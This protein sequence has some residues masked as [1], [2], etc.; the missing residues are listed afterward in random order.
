MC[1]KK[2]CHSAVP[3]HHNDFQLETMRVD[4]SFHARKLSNY[5][6]GSVEAPIFRTDRSKNERPGSKILITITRRA[7]NR[8]ARTN[9]ANRGDEGGG[10][11]RQTQL[12]AFPSSVIL[13]T[14]RANFRT[15]RHGQVDGSAVR[16][17]APSPRPRPR[18]PPCSPPQACINSHGGWPTSSC[19]YTIRS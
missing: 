5:S 13:L 15:Q 3:I 7:R 16:S 11:E 12:F 10:G 4:P 17:P 1:R 9:Y 19:L 6:P 2:N 14:V 8:C 18:P